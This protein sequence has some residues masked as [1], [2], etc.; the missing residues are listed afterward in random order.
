MK[1]ILFG[2]WILDLGVV[3]SYGLMVAANA[4]ANILPINQVMTG[5][6]S[7]LYANL[8]APAPITFAIWGLIYLLLAVYVFYQMHVF[9]PRRRPLQQ[10][11]FNAV[12]WAFILSSLANTAWIFAWHYQWI[13][14][15]MIL[16]A[17]VLVC[18]I[19]SVLTLS[20]MQLELSDVQWI[21]VPMLIYFGWLTIANI[22]NVTTYLV[23]MDWNRFN[24]TE[25]VLMIIVLSVGVLIGSVVANRFKSLSYLAVLIWA[26]VGILLKHTIASP[27]FNYQYPDIIMTLGI[28]LLIFFGLGIRILMF[29][30]KQA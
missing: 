21:Y 24:L 2:Q 1:R 5:E 4:A 16:I 8:F 15:S 22:A 23:Y 9:H 28:A 29:K 10:R 25:S 30:S 14:V 19:F 12:A 7:D 17:I 27:G 20:D 11:R 26:Y 18:L 3:F 13:G 6:I